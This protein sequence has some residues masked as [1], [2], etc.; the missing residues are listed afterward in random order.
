MGRQK[1]E[2][3]VVTGGFG[4]IGSNFIR[5]LLRRRIGEI[6]NVDNLTYGSNRGNLA[7][8]REDSRYRFL[9]SDI[10]SKKATNLI[11]EDATAVVNFAAETHVDRS[12]SDSRSFVNT[13]ILGVYSIL[14]AMRK[15]RNDIRLVQV[16][17]DEEYGEIASGA[18]AENDVLHPSSPYAASKASASMLINA[19]HRTYGLKVMIT[20]STNNFGPYQFPEKL[21]P[22]SIIRASL[23]MRVPIYGDGKNIRDW[24]YV[25]DNCEAIG[26]VLHD[27]RAGEVYNISSGNELENVQVIAEVLSILKKPLGLV[28]YIEDRPGHDCRYSLDSSKIRTQLGWKPQHTFH[29]SLRNTVR[30]YTEHKSWWTPLASRKILHPTPWRLRW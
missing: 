26:R 21:I 23:G 12:I 28:K 16:G 5:L 17:T 30:W 8:L 9:K 24:L 11:S 6:T 25:D 13:N 29:N 4:F 10:V 18:F 20:R 14:E 27:G 1:F 7:E 15:A 19:Y 2:R 22:K 3:L